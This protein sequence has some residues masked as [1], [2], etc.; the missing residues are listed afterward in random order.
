MAWACGFYE[1]GLGGMRY[2]ASMLVGFVLASLVFISSSPRW[3]K[4]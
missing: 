2:F 4:T 1:R 3:G